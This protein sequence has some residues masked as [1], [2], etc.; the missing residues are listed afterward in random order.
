MSATI[1]PTT[2]TDLEEI[3]SA[4]GTPTWE[5]ARLFPRQGQ[6][7]ESEYLALETNHLVELIDGCLEFLPMPTLFHERIVMFLLAALMSWSKEHPEFGE[8]GFAPLPIRLNPGRL[9]EPDLMVFKEDHVSNPHL[10]LTGADFVLEV[11][12]PGG[13]NRKRDFEEKLHDYAQASIPEYW[14]V[15][16]KECQIQIYVLLNGKSRYRLHGTFGEGE[17]AISKLLE[18]FSVEVTTVFA[19]GEAA[20]S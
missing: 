6:W 7:T 14:I 18:G 19:A 1:E 9:R 3:R 17:T 12:S 20:R 16:P 10:P 4:P 13:E 5:I 2:P 8:V 15:D 11:V